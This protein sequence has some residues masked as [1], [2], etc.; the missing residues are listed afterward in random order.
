MARIPWA[1]GVEFPMESGY[2]F[3]LA[4]CYMASKRRSCV[5]EAGVIVSNLATSRKR[6]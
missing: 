2:V 1:P 6:F 3:R 4:L 5:T